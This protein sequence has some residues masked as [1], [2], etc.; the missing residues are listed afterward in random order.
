MKIYGKHI[1]M[2][3]LL[4][5]SFAVSKDQITLNLVT[6][7]FIKIYKP[8][9]VTDDTIFANTL[10]RNIV[11][12]NT[13]LVNIRAEGMDRIILQNSPSSMIGIPLSDVSSFRVDKQESNWFTYLIIITAGAVTGYSIPFGSR[14]AQLREEKNSGRVM[15]AAAGILTG[16]F[17]AYHIDKKY[18]KTQQKVVDLSGKSNLEKAE[19]LRAQNY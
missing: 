19:L 12:D 9:T 17:L 11:H 1:L 14:G 4:C 2:G 15:F 16:Y 13:Q 18:R 10:D 6:G 5:F 3:M 8:V 7:N